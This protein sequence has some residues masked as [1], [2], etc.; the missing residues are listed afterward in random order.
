MFFIL[1]IVMNYFLCSLFNLNVTLQSPV[2][3]GTVILYKICHVCFL[4]EALTFDIFLFLK[5]LLLQLFQPFRM[6]CYCI[7][8]SRDP[9][10]IKILLYI[11]GLDISNYQ[12]CLS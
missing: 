4:S 1:F 11:R 8:V 7:L 5:Y 2:Y 12:L 9:R 10:P 3:Q 6:P